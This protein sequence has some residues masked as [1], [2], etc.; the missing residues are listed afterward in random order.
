MHNENG[1]SNGWNAA[2]AVLPAYNRS[3]VDETGS[4]IRERFLECEPRRQA[5][6]SSSLVYVANS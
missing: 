1:Y 6:E 5:A 3:N 2:I 4:G